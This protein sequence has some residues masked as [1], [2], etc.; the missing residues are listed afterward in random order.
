MGPGRKGIRDWFA[1]P[2]SEH[3]AIHSLGSVEAAEWMQSDTHLLDIRIPK[4]HKDSL[5]SLLH[6]LV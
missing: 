1:L 2:L 5:I 3:R 4:V 6:A